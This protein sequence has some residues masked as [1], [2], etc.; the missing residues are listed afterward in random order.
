M[1]D[2]EDSNVQLG[3]IVWMGKLILQMQLIEK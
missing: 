1:A 2:F 3:K